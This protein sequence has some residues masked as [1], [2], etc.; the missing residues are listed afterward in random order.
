MDSETKLEMGVEFLPLFDDVDTDDATILEDFH[1]MTTQYLEDEEMELTPR[2]YIRAYQDI[3]D[4]LD[5]ALLCKESMFHGLNV[6]VVILVLFRTVLIYFRWWYIY[7][8]RVHITFSQI[9][10]GA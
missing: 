6:F 2:A 4:A 9:I 3:W 10:M 7:R 8:G 5:D 1:N